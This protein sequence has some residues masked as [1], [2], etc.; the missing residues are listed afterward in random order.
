[1]EEN[2]LFDTFFVKPFVYLL[3]FFADTF[4]GS[5]GVSIVLVTLVVRFCLLPL[6]Y[7]QQKQQ[8][9]IQAKMLKLKPDLDVF[10]QKLKEAKTKEQRQDIQQQM[11]SL[12]SE[13]Q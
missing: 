8:K 4:Q 3:N 13:H 12:Y 11:A 6:F 10:Q 2:N 9:Y 1:M 7:K 5:Y